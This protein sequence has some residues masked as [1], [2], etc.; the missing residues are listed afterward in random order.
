MADKHY[1]DLDATEEEV[2]SVVK[3]LADIVRYS[4][5]DGKVVGVRWKKGEDK[6]KDAELGNLKAVDNREVAF[7]EIKKD[8]IAVGDGEKWLKGSGWVT[9]KVQ[10]TDGSS[11]YNENVISNGETGRVVLS[12][13]K[14]ENNEIETVT[15]TTPAAENNQLSYGKIVLQD[16]G[17][18]HVGGN[19]RVY[20]DGNTR[21]TLHDNAWMD[22]NQNA[23][24]KFGNN[25]Y[26]IF[27]PLKGGEYSNAKFTFH[28][29]TVDISPTVTQT[30]PNGSTV[31]KG[32]TLI[33]HDDAFVAFEGDSRFYFRD[34]NTTFCMQDGAQFYM[35]VTG[36]SSMPGE[37]DKVPPLVIFDSEQFIFTHASPDPTYAGLS[38]IG[39]KM[40][41]QD[42]SNVKASISFVN[43][44]PTV[45]WDSFFTNTTSSSLQ[46]THA[47]PTLV[48]QNYSNI[49]IGG[50]GKTF[51]RM[52]PQSNAKLILD[53]TPWS[54]STSAIKFGPY[55]DAKL[56]FD[57]TP[58]AQSETLVKFGGGTSSK[59]YFDITPYASSTSYIKFS[60]NGGSKFKLIVDPAQST[61]QYY[62]IGG[63]QHSNVNF[64]LD[65]ARNTTLDIK[66]S[67]KSAETTT[68]STPK[69][70]TTT[71]Q[72]PT[73]Q[74]ILTDQIFVQMSANSHIEM[75]N[76]SVF[77]MRGNLGP[78][79]EPW[80]DA[81]QYG[82]EHE[83]TRPLPAR[84]N[85]PVLSMNDE[86]VF[87]M[88]KRFLEDSE[89][90]TYQG[91]IRLK[92]AIREEQE[93]QINAPYTYFAN[94][95][96]PKF[97]EIK[98]V[99]KKNLPENF[100]LEED[101]DGTKVEV[102]KAH[103]Y[104]SDH[105]YNI[106]VS[107]FKYHVKHPEWWKPQ[108]ERKPDCPLLEVVDNAE[109]RF[110]G[111]MKIETKNRNGETIIAFSKSDVK[112]NVE[113]KTE[114][115]QLVEF[116]LSD[117]AKLKKLI[118]SAKEE[119]SLRTIQE[120]G[121]TEDENE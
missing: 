107:K 111:S 54:G 19:T 110:G 38:N 40:Q 81:E 94:S 48:V 23:H 5:T 35:Q 112:P 88:H 26:F 58:E 115:E 28:G 36:S 71:T 100:I 61:T 66:I 4:N 7:V 60:P 24:V 106:D 103:N 121:E 31:S 75:H 52:A 98:D 46:S 70:T 59:L 16:K 33:L 114:E 119:R 101:Q 108:V 68:A 10:V 74:F 63:G 78:D 9:K 14:T 104:I 1:V 6:E 62:K 73:M 34:D 51:L 118:E 85:G 80:Q 91:T 89:V 105:I 25:A 55:N 47:S 27:D 117:L 43:N 56:K 30:P 109:L 86:S 2:K 113:K 12:N 57:I 8:E 65:P 72:K 102:N 53:I 22:I 95:D 83:W 29:G 87:V 15:E 120:N 44:E 32:P 39:Y 11:T 90:R 21:L 20:L 42:A 13:R 18:L 17:Q 77:A 41:D 97:D 37:S 76:N 67:P 45:T 116:T 82:T 3:D 93:T 69:E 96:D 99:L 64:V 49:V 50:D 84:E 79:I 92:V